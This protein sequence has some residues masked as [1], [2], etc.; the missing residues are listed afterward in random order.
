MACHATGGKNGVIPSSRGVN[1]HPDGFKNVCKA[2]A[3]KNDRACLKCHQQSELVT[4]GC[5]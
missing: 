5:E 1:P 2:L 3:S 4:L